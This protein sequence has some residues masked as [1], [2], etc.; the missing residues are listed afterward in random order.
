LEFGCQHIHRHE[1][2][3][4]GAS[5]LEGDF[6]DVDMAEDLGTA[7]REEEHEGGGNS[8]ALDSG[9]HLACAN[10]RAVHNYKIGA[11]PTASMTTK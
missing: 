5:N 6:G 2:Q 7:Q 11:L 4:D 8:S 3:D 10:L 9:A 1:K